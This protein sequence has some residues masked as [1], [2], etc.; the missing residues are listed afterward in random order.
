MFHRRLALQ[1]VVI[2]AVMAALTARLAVL[3]LAES[4]QRRGQ[5]EAR[6]VKRSWMPTVRGRVFDREGRVLAMD[7]PSYSVAVSYG[8]LSGEWSR[9]QG[10]QMAARVLGERWAAADGATREKLAGPFIERYEAHVSR[11]YDRIAEISK[12]PREVL[13]QRAARI[14]SGVDR[15][16]RAVADTRLNRLVESHLASGRGVD[17]EVERR[18]GRAAQVPV[19]EERTAHVLVDDLADELAFA[20]KRMTTRR[21]PVF[22]EGEPGH[23]QTSEVYTDLLPGVEIRGSTD[24]VRPFDRIEVAIDRS[25]LPGPMRGE[26]FETITITGVAW[27]TLGTMRTRVFSEDGERRRAWLSAHPEHSA[28]LAGIDRGRYVQGDAVGQ[29]GIE[30]AYEHELRGLRGLRTVRLDSGRVEEFPPEAGGDVR[31]TIDAMLEARIRA[32]L[33]P[34]VGLTTVQPWHGNQ[35]VPEGETLAGAVVVLDVHSGHVL[36]MVSTPSPTDAARWIEE[37]GTPV[38]PEYLDPYINRAV[39]VPYPPGSIVK[40]LVLAEAVGR[41]FHRVSD[42]IVCTGHLLE[43]RNDLYRCWIYKRY[44][45]THSPTGQPVR[46]AESIKVSCNIF[47]YTLG[48]RLGAA[49]ITSIYRDLGVGTG[50]SL[51]IGREWPGRVGSVAGPGDGSDLGISDAIL[52]AM[53]QGP[54]TWTPLHAANAYAMLARGGAWIEP[55]VVDTGLPAL[56]ERMIRLDP[57]AIDAAMRGLHESVNDQGGTGS[58]INFGDRRERIFNHPGIDIWGKTGTAQAPPLQHEGRVVR[59]GDH[60]WFVLLTGPAGGGPRYAV[61][62]L[63]EYGGGGGRV[64]GPVASQVV[65]ALIEEGYLPRSGGPAGFASGGGR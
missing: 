22:S 1:L 53:G 60:A 62:V 64:A 30:H 31:L 13:D 9:S 28:L 40:P 6:L 24:R 59:S 65:H 16:R 51:G 32:V 12:T 52:M 14:L 58:T 41:G 27:H 10:R 37:E 29:R 38:Y 42:G 54:V 5:A 17:E 4:E 23:D 7:R 48:R 8:V 49:E 56:A 25:T 20:L 63:I 35:G 15:T 18:L 33:E 57:A 3:T 46:A 45:F 21:V 11:M 47:Y 2:A 26:G 61:S 55:S 39:A 36:A 50:F 34:G 44:G 43:D 19:V